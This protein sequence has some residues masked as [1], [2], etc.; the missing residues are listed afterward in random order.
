MAINPLQLPSYAAPQSLDF[1]SLAQL[2]QVYKQAQADAVRRQTLAELGQGG[3]IDP[4]R[5]IQSGDMNLANLGIGIMNRQQEQARQDRSEAR[6]DARDKAADARSA[7]AAGLAERQFAFQ[8]EQ[9]REKPSIQKLKVK[10]EA[11]NETETLVRVMPDGS[12]TNLRTGAAVEGAPGGNPFGPGKFNETQ[13]K[14]AGFADR[15]LQSEGILSGLD[16][17]KGLDAKGT[18]LPSYA[19]TNAPYVPDV[20]KNKMLTGDYQKYDQAKRDF[21]NAQLRRESGAVISPE[22]FNSA[23][24]QYFPMPGDDPEVLKQKRKNRRAAVEAMGREGGQ[25]YRP[26]FIYGDDG[27]LKAYGK[28]APKKTTDE[29]VDWQTYFGGSQ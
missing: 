10:D 24:K 3:Q 4:M 21:I 22:E 17:G 19:I 18:E 9:A 20:V 11:G 16:G 29:V 26:K 23:N 2:P 14:A 13:G 27:T 5:L 7:R 8:Q 6:Q 15:M 12:F 28:S 1:S 25:S